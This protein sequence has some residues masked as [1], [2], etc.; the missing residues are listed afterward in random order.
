[1]SEIETFE[2]QIQMINIHTYAT[3][4]QFYLNKP[5]IPCTTYWFKIYAFFTRL[6][7][8]NKTTALDK[9]N[10]SITTIG[11]SPAF[12]LSITAP[13]HYLDGHYILAQHSPATITCQRRKP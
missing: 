11:R 8:M 10:S 13:Y 12:L 4:N 5:D 9:L 3:V 6:Q 1:M 2:T 7:Q